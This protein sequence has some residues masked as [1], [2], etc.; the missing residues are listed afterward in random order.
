LNPTAIA[1]VGA[2]DDA[3]RNGGRV[4][5]NVINCGF[6]GRILPVNPRHESVFGLTC[7]PSIKDVPGPPPEVAFVS[8]RAAD[9]TSALV[10]CA[11]AGVKCC[12]IPAVGFAEMGEAGAR[13]QEEIRDLAQRTG[14]RLIG[15]NC[16]GLVTSRC[17]LNLTS[18]WTLNEAPAVGNIGLISQSGSMLKYLYHRAADFGSGITSGISIGNQVDL[19]VSDFIEEMVED[20]STTVICG[21][22]EGL[23]DAKRFLRAA[24][25]CLKAGKPLLI[26]KAGRTTIGASITRSH[27]A[28]MAT[29]SAVFEAMARN[30]G[31][32]LADDPDAMIATAIAL[33]R[34]RYPQAE[35]VAILSG[36]GGGLASTLDRA[37]EAGL[38]IPV[39]EETLRLEIGQHVAL[40]SDLAAVDIGRR[41]RSGPPVQVGEIARMMASDPNVGAVIFAVTVMPYMV[42]RTV[43]A[44][45]AV[46]DA[47]K[48][49][50]PTLLPGSVADDVGVAL[51]DAGFPSF[52][53][54]DEAIRFASTWASLTKR[55][56]MPPTGNPPAMSCDTAARLASLPM[57]GLT[58][59]EAKEVL[60]WSGIAVNRGSVAESA[61]E[62]VAVAEEL[63]Y[64]VAVKLI[65]REFVHKSDVGGVKLNLPDAVA[66][67]TA[68]KQIET[69]VRLTNSPQYLIQEMV[70]SGTE[71]LVGITRDHQFGPVVTVGFGGVFTELVK[72]VCLAPAPVSEDTAL[73]M[74]HRLKTWPFLAGSR[75]L[76]QQSVSELASVISRLSWLA[77]NLGGRLIEFEINPLICNTA[78]AFAVDAR[79]TLS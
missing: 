1:I 19:G 79:G 73:S 61:E 45:I 4:V 75:G 33:D 48:Q 51:R 72:D 47:G 50:I 13:L 49:F 12:V 55:G 59:A 68:C 62:A 35:G 38:S 37:T 57:G 3:A 16:L 23:R 28:S 70:E 74:L 20:P 71:L 11:S 8:I 43:E 14:M 15:P 40:P 41:E 63:G 76:P 46:R 36:S 65:S 77:V 53:H 9:L 78:G 10:D 27:T 67:R 69:A 29:P 17:K 24:D 26:L 2:S 42:E 60:R 30:H 25:A 56:G 58:E 66:V 39:L 44:A 18:G 32:I 6:R 31:I 21:Y 7:Y 52:A 5:Y 64:P 54:I 22:V 34:G